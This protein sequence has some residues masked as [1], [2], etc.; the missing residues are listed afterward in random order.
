MIRTPGTLPGLAAVLFVF[1]LPLAL[2][3]QRA[4]LPEDASDHPMISPYEGSEMLAYEQVDYDRQQLPAPA[5][6]GEFEME[7]FEGEV[8]RILY[9]APEGLSTFQVHR[10]YEMALRNAG[11]EIVGECVNENDGCDYHFPDLEKVQDTRKFFMGHDRCYFLARK[12][13]AGGDVRVSVHTERHTFHEELEGRP[14]TLLQVV[15]EKPMATGKVRASLDAGAM[16]DDLEVAGTVR[17]YGIHFE[18]D[19]ATIQPASEPTLAEIADLLAAHPGLELAVVGHTDTRGG[20]EHN[21]SLSERRAAAVVEYLATEHGVAAD[22]LEA[23]G[24]A[25]LAPV[26]TN[27]TEEGRARN[28]RVELVELP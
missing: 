25:W 5:E 17:V 12:P 7:P 13:G 24:V 6:E 22:R 2:A 26:A 8:T 3:A 9:V 14:V 16:A 11:F 19:E 4:E 23:H 21:V 27:E 1:S 28:R 20:F 10:N 15:E 18:T